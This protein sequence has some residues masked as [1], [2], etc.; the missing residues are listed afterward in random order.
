L[1]QRKPVT[2]DMSNQPEIKKAVAFRSYKPLDRDLDNLCIEQ[3][4]PVGP[5]GVSKR[6]D[7]SLQV[8]QNLEA[9]VQQVVG[10]VDQIKVAP[11]DVD[12]DLKRDASKRLRKLARET[13][14]AI[15]RIAEQERIRREQAEEGAYYSIDGD[16]DGEDDDRDQDQEGSEENPEK[17][18]EGKKQT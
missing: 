15:L 3:K 4:T 11:N 13:Q 6:N 1:H 9:Y 8:I 17:D 10:N 2:T 12:W 5:A 7:T 14:K 16:G 18:G